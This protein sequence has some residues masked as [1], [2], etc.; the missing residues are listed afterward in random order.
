MTSGDKSYS[1]LSGRI[2]AA[3]QSAGT[4]TGK[5]P[6]ARRGVPFQ[7]L[8]RQ[9]WQ[10]LFLVRKEFLANQRRSMFGLF[11][12]MFLPMVPIMAY[13]VLR[14]VVQSPPGAD[15]IHPAV[16]VTLGV[17]LWLLFR[18]MVRVPLHSVSRYA[19][20]IANTE[21]SV[22]GAVIVGFGGILLDTLF[23]FLLCIPVILVTMDV[24]HMPDIGL[25]LLFLATGI[26]FFFGIGLISIPIAALF[27]DLKQLYDTLFNYLIFFSL[28]IFPF[29]TDDGLGHLMIYNP[30]AVVIDSVRLA[31]VV[32]R[33]PHI[34]TIWLMVAICP[35]L[36]MLG[37]LAI[38]RTNSRLKEAFL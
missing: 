29:S 5:Q 35:V 15:G 6:R 25:S 22:M 7:P 4:K 13:L 27:P 26:I 14:M 10:I 24:V 18:D 3:R 37:G 9:R 34:Q 28:A 36:L 20:T 38:G 12:S 21:L 32:G 2:E 11:W 19:S 17:T 30:F 31:I 1:A 23:R 16:Y 8:W 33:E